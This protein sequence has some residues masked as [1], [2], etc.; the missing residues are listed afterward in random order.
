VIAIFD[1]GS[2][3]HEVLPWR[4]L[5][6]GTLVIVHDPTRGGGG[7]DGSLRCYLAGRVRDGKVETWSTI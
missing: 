6:N 5:P 3:G 4:H 2:W 7:P 1:S